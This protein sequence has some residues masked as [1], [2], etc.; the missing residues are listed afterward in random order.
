MSKKNL[1]TEILGAGL[2]GRTPIPARCLPSGLHW[3]LLLPEIAEIAA[4]L[5]SVSV[6]RTAERAAGRAPTA[7]RAADR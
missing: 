1:Q 2:A 3:A 5:T 4:F 6:E 7:I